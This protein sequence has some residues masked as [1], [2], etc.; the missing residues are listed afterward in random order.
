MRI[1]LATPIFPPETGGPATYTRELAERLKQ[2]HEITVVTYADAPEAMAGVKMVAISKEKPLLSRLAAYFFA[3]RSESKKADIIYVQNAVAAG[4]PAALVGMVTGK[5]VVLKFVGDEAWERATQ[6]GLIKKPLDEFLARPTANF[7]IGLFIDVQRFVLSHVSKVLP[8]SDFL[9]TI[10]TT[11]YGV[12]A[13]KV[14][15]NY[16]AVDIAAPVLVARKPHQVVSVGRLVAWKHVDGIIRAVGILQKKF[17]DVHLVVAGEGPEA[18]SLHTLAATLGLSTAVEFRGRLS[19]A[20]TAQL[21]AESAVQVLNSTYE[22]LPHIALESFA[23]RTPLVA[24]NI[25]GT[26]EA[27][28]D[29]QTGLLVLPQDDQKLADAI[30]RYFTDPALCQKVV[31]GGTA[32]LSDTFSW[33]RHIEKLLAVFILLKQ[34]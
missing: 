2:A 8:P 17:P 9:R 25:P 24:T 26:A 28:V 21:Q 7:K 22:G 27:V 20:E 6:V 19:R 23:M 1:V 15:V 34:S 31:A 33:H 29:G 30:E 4:L 32:A 16:N 11:H 5:P 12:D 13:Q 10:I 14:Q 3:L 18:D